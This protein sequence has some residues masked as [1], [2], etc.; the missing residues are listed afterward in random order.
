[1]SSIKLSDDWFEPL[2]Y[3]PEN[4]IVEV[5]EEDDDVIDKPYFGID[6]DS[7]RFDSD[8]FAIWCDI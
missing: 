5:L 2:E 4:V 8:T 6:Y 1:M 3:A 7:D